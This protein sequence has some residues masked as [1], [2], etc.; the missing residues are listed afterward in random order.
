M[1]VVVDSVA[2]L[3]LARAAEVAF[4]G[5][6]I[7]LSESVRARIAA[8]RIRFEGYLDGQGGNLYG[9]TT[10]PGSRATVVLGR[11]EEVERRT[12]TMGRFMTLRGG[13]GGAFLPPRCVRLAILARL[14]N[15]LTGQ[16][17]LRLPTVQALAGLLAD[18][19]A[20]PL[21][22][23]ASSGE[24]V[25]LSWLLAPLAGLPLGTGE[26]MALINGSPFATGMACDVALTLERRLRIAEQLLAMSVVAAGCPREHFDL[27]LSRQWPDPYYRQALDRLDELLGPPPGW[28]LDHQAPTSWRLIPNILAGA[29]QAL[30]EV[31]RA[32]ELG[33]TSLKDN[34]TFLAGDDRDPQQDTLASS[35]GYH[36]HRA[37]KA[38]DQVNSLLVDLCVLASRQVFRFLDGVGLGLPPL[39]ATPGDRV[40]LEYLAW[41][42]TEPLASAR[43]AATATTL[44]VGVHDPAGNQSDVASLAFVAYAKHRQ[45]VRAF[46][47]CLSV[48]A[49]TAALALDLRQD[50]GA[51]LV[52]GICESVLRLVGAA[53]DRAEAASE[54]LRAIRDLITSSAEQLSRHDFTSVVG[55]RSR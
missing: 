37:A 3:T 21:Q 1:T 7:E 26:A 36:D 43:A 18:P 20:V 2:D 23:T 24:V 33:L 47:D 53:P 29:L 49:V 22:G 16:G 11:E 48:L 44:D 52:T 55:S 35:G 14:S 50:D 41:S 8:G 9:I 30:D 51:G 12:A 13:A 19:P 38:I 5:A 45:I 32:A 34:P 25:A 42:L 39:L 15:A 40:G 54:P 46:D 17:K 31:T 6:G 4:D 27:R 10:A 28:Q